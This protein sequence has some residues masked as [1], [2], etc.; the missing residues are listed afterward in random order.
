[1]SKPSNIKRQEVSMKTKTGRRRR[2][3]LKRLGRF[4]AVTAPAVT[5]LLAAQ[6][7]PGNAAPV[8][9][10]PIKSSRAFKISGGAVDAAAVLAAVVALPIRVQ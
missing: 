7:K 6:T 1:M 8:S 10:A 5:L 4:A 9:C 3:L 2:A